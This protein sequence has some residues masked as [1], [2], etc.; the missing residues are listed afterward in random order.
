MSF[1]SSSSLISFGYN[2]LDPRLDEEA[3]LPLYLEILGRLVAQEADH[4]AVLAKLI[5]QW[6]RQLLSKELCL[7]TPRQTRRS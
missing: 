5:S 1:F 2:R 4:N 3:V 6:R 7:I